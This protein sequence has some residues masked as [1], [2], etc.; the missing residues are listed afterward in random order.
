MHRYDL[1]GVI[2]MLVNCS[3]YVQWIMGRGKIHITLFARIIALK[4][5]LHFF[6]FIDR[7]CFFF[8]ASCG[9]YRTFRDLTSFLYPFL[10]PFFFFFLFV[11][12]FCGF[13]FKPSFF[14]PWRLWG[15]VGGSKQ[16]DRQTSHAWFFFQSFNNRTERQK[17]ASCN[18]YRVV[19]FVWWKR[20]SA[21]W[22]IALLHS[23]KQIWNCRG[24]L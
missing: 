16:G 7:V 23:T 3:Y 22:E 15:G 20:R 14:V 9:S 11:S 5:H 24:P 18:S 13:F 12:W 2:L 21:A 17:G 10:H 1:E 4:W 19:G 8:A 6:S